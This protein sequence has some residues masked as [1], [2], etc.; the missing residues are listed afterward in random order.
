MRPALLCLACACGG[1]PREPAV[2]AQPHQRVASLD[3]DSP[4]PLP[5]DPCSREPEAIGPGLFA[6]RA[7]LFGTPV[8]GDPPCVIVLRADLAHFRARLLT[9]TRDGVA[10]TAPQWRDAFELAAV[11]NAGMFHDS[12]APVALLVEDGVAIGAD[13][14]KMGGV[15]A[16]DPRSASDPPVVITG[17]DC[18]GFDLR[19]LRTRYRSLLQA[20]RLLGCEG[21]A[22]PWSDPKHYSAAAVGVDRAGRLV[23]LHARAA[24]TMTELARSLA[25]PDL[26]LQGALFLEGGPE[27]SLL[28]HGPHGEVSRIGSY[29]TGFLEADTNEE[30]WKL[31]NVLALAPR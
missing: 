1:E 21:K 6:Q 23:L 11:I 3:A 2:A 24:V 30:F 22:L 16:F 4:R 13:N 15:L 28:A 17:R 29:E 10:R 9:A 7:P 19:A 12:G 8:A 14:P 26:D 31:P 20:P 25:A 5:R 18:A 27:A